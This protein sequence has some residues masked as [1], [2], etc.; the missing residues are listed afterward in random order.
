ML[1]Q[2]FTSIIV[3]LFYFTFCNKTHLV[4]QILITNTIIISLNILAKNLTF[5][6]IK[7]EIPLFSIL[8]YTSRI[9]NALFDWLCTILLSNLTD[10]CNF[11]CITII[12]FCFYS[13]STSIQRFAH[14]HCSFQNYYS[15]PH[16]VSNIKPKRVQHREK[17][18]LF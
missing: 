11:Y 9:S 17:N 3:N 16:K 14:C 18:K 13:F 2:Q 10:K 7:H 6:L 15:L 8:L 5:I 1:K 4:S 12:S